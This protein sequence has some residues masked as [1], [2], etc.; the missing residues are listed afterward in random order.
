METVQD[1]GMRRKEMAV[2]DCALSVLVACLWLV[3]LPPPLI[4]F[5]LRYKCTLLQGSFTTI[6][7]TSLA[8]QEQNVSAA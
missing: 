3:V 7:F 5:L 1:G 6:F 2:C 8:K 4:L